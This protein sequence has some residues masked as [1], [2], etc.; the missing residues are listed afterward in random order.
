MSILEQMRKI[1]ELFEYADVRLYVGRNI[2]E[3]ESEISIFV[4]DVVYPI[5]VTD[6]EWET[7]TAPTDI[8][9]IIAEYERKS[10][11]R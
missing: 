10:S 7:G 2:G 1:S 6:D 5:R 8:A 11:G 9:N 4:G 3:G